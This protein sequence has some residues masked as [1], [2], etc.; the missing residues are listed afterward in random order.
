MVL[1]KKPGMNY[2]EIQWGRQEGG[3]SSFP[4]WNNLAWYLHGDR[5]PTSSPLYFT[6][7]CTGDIPDLSPITE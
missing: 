1:V 3:T 7:N 2:Q 4:C 5:K 6:I